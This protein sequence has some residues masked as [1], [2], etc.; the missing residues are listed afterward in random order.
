MK[1]AYGGVLINEMA[2]FCSGS[3]RAPQNP[4]WTFAKG[5]QKDGENAQ[6]TA[7]REVLEETGVRAKVISKY[8]FPQKTGGSR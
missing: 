8:W 2:G 3:Q 7:L 5:K 6:Q 1:R 4:V